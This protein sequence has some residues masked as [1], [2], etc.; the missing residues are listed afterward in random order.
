MAMLYYIKNF[1][2]AFITDGRSLA[3]L[4]LSDVPIS[5]K[6]RVSPFVFDPLVPF[7][8]YRGVPK[9]WIHL[10]KCYVVCDLIACTAH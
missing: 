9:F 10:K 2:K 1:R 8:W 3:P 5:G 7:P 6:E 4:S